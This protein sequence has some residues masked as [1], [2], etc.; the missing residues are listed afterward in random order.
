MNRR[1]ALGSLSILSTLVLVAGATVALF[2]DQAESKGNTF[3]TGNADLQIA[4][5][6]ESPG[7]YGDDIPAPAFEAENI[8][9]GFNQDFTFW[10]KNNSSAD[11]GLDVMVE[12][13]NLGGDPELQ[14]ALLVKFTCARKGDGSP[15][16]ETTQKSV[17][18]WGVA[19]SLGTL[20]ENDDGLDGT[21]A[22]EMECQ[23]NVELPS[24]VEDDVAD[25]GVTYD[26]VFNATQSAP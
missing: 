26:G 17:S 8:A 22:D 13:N 21:G 7:A 2:T 12:L 4:L 14:D 19:E 5:E 25:M 3:S 1:I 16:V 24:D 23:M 9:P 15:V 10:L 11:I 18:A 6:A 20:T